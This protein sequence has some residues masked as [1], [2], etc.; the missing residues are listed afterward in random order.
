MKTVIQGHGEFESFDERVA[1]IFRVWREEHESCLW[2][3]DG[4]THP[5]TFIAALSEDLLG[6]FADLPLLDP[7]DI[8]QRL[9]DYWDGTM[10]DDV[11]LVVA[12][13]WFDAAQPRGV[14]E[15]KQKKIKE[16]PDLT[17]KRKKYKLDLIP[18]DLV[19]ARYFDAERQAI[20]AL[21]VEHESAAQELDEY[22]EEHGG[23]DGLLESVL[24]DKGKVTKAA[25]QSRLKAIR[26]EGEPDSDEERDVLAHCL[27]LI[28]AES[29]AGKAANEAWAALDQR[30]LS[31][32]AALTETEVKTLVVEDKWL[33]GIR[34][35][36]EGEV[37]RLTQR[38]AARVQ[39]IEERY[40]DRLPELERQVVKF[41]S[42][43]KRHLKRMGLSP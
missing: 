6:R 32:Y 21:S 15:D 22:V 30:V 36:V 33:A 1:D 38:L 5:R 13:G 26:K 16:T 18:P 14:I 35:A 29:K 23:E 24:T 7:Y 12:D 25:V 8:Y 31:R 9:M 17:A 4:E 19:V 37:Q 11:Y 34:S 43:V 39:E 41:G 10:Q 28:E 42:K 40:A 2:G 27:A 3:I 20:E